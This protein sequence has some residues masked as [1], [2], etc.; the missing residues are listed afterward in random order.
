MK[1][2]RQYTYGV[3]NV[4][5]AGDRIAWS[6]NV[7]LMLLISLNVLSVILETLP[8]LDFETQRFFNHFEVVSVI[9]F[10]L[11]YI[12]RVWSAVESENHRYH[13]PII[14]RLRYML[15]PMLILDLIVILPLYLGFFLDI[16]LRFIRAIRLLRVIRL[17]RYSSSMGLLKQVFIEESSAIMTSLFVLL[18]LI[19]MTSSLIYL[20][21]HHAQPQAFSSIPAAMWWSIVTLTTIGYGD[22]VPVTLAGK[23]LACV[24]GIVSFGIVALPAGL[25]ASGFSNA[26]HKRRAEYERVAEEVLKDGLITKDERQLLKEKQ[27][28]LNI[29]SVEA[30]QILFDARQRL[31]DKDTAVNVEEI[32]AAVVAFTDKSCP[33]CGRPITWQDKGD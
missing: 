26:L 31:K 15:R 10:T 23:I 16:D 27:S 6:I 9:I 24:I 18:I 19:V 28:S 7:F 12:A 4:T 17:T 29:S 20:A 14:G 25:L 13:H 3:F 8:N 5:E 30:R 33:H 2:L 21:E 22:V 11:E 1:K 32:K